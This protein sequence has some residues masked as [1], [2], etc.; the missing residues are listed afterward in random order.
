MRHVVVLAALAAAACAPPGSAA[1]SADSGPARI[2]TTGSGAEVRV[3]GDGPAAAYAVP[4][5]PDEV[6]NALP[7]VYT[8]LGVPEGLRDHTTGTYGN[9]RHVLRRTLD[10]KP[11]SRYLSCGYTATGSPIADS[12]RVQLS[13]VTTVK[14][15]AGGSEVR[16]E[17]GATAQSIEGASSSAVPCASTGRLEA[18]IAELLGARVQR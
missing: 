18:R 9:R 2:I 12:Y 4:S 15:A 14:P 7:G 17:V 13:V 5:A 6:W 1:T 11:L 3:G 16:T 10:G 8:T